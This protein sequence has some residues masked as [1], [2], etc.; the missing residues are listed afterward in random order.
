MRSRLLNVSSMKKS[1][2][3]KSRLKPGEPLKINVRIPRN[4]SLEQV[5]SLCHQNKIDNKRLNLSKD[6][7]NSLR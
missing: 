5:L 6:L 4:S 2:L 1:L 3:E 7:D